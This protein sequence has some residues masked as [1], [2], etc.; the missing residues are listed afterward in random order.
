V[1]KS[2][3]SWSLFPSEYQLP[4]TLRA[5]EC[6]RE[7]KEA[8]KKLS[9]IPAGQCLGYSIKWG[10]WRVEGGGRRRSGA[11]A[12]VSPTCCPLS[13]ILSPARSPFRCCRTVSRGVFGQASRIPEMGICW[14]RRPAIRKG[15]CGLGVGPWSTRTL[16]EGKNWTLGPWWGTM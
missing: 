5:G 12:V 7:K 11:A 6:S 1:Q 14:E 13:K 10:W 3:L 15:S 16:P 8:E 2:F 4:I 9:Q